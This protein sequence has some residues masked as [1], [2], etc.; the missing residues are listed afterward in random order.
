MP[1]VRKPAAAFP[2]PC[3]IA[4]FPAILL[5]TLGVAVLRIWVPRLN[6]SFWL[7]ET[8][9]AWTIRDGLGH[10][11]PN[12]FVSLQSISF[13]L[14]EWLV[15]SLGGPLEPTLRLLPMAAGIS[16]LYV[17]YRIGVEMLDSELGMI[18][19]ALCVSLS[20]VAVEATMARPY[21]V[22]LFAHTAAILWLLRWLRSGR[23]R[24]GVWWAVCAAI[25]GHLHYFFFVA[26]P[27]EACVALWFGIKQA[28]IPRRQ[29]AICTSGIAVLI[30]PAV[31][32]ALVLLKLGS[33]LSFALK[34]TAANLLFT[35]VPV[36]LVVALALLVAGAG[37]A[38]SHP[39]WSKPASGGE[40]VA[41]AV[42]LLLVTVAGCFALSRLTS[43]SL[44]INRYLLP[45]A[46]GF[47]ILWGWLLRGFE[48]AA[49]RRTALIATAALSIV[50]IGG[51]SGAAASA[52]EDWRSAVHSLPDSGALLVYGGLV[53][54]RRIDW[55]QSQPRW[56]Y[57]AAP[58]GAYRPSISPRNVFNLPYNSGALEQ[59]YVERLLAGPLR[60]HHTV[61]LIARGGLSGRDWGYWLSQRLT[62]NGFR[63]L[64]TSTHGSVDVRVFYLPSTENASNTLPG[65]PPRLP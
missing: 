33:L 53:E 34:P 56:S 2:S 57:L 18:F 60:G 21:A 58:V 16:T 35:L 61:T 23:M 9:I 7:D 49:L 36:V 65:A 43:V 25:A 31:P 39:R 13:C 11:I 32:Q 63:D 50:Q 19:S 4:W 38:G 15:W 17:F 8:L 64:G 42:L 47:V 52:A 46:P 44:F 6:V 28:R 20:A 51:P 29:I 54:A 30:L 24:D 37:M 59:E 41:L 62:G 40:A 5:I 3:P 1:E 14:L 45:A 10:V 27:L 12:A 48:P 55:L 26:V 22:A